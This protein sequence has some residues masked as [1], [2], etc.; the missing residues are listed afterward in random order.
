MHGCHDL[1]NINLYSLCY[2][3]M[4]AYNMCC[5]YNVH[6][7]HDLTNI[8]TH[9][10]LLSVSFILFV[11]CN[12]HGSYDIANINIHN[13]CYDYMLAYNIMLPV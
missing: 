5:L 9:S 1:T 10:L 2:Y 6:G 13:L 12:V 4:L 11:V 8:N 7:C 3:Y